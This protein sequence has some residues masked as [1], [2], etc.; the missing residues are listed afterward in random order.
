MVDRK[1]DKPK[2][3]YFAEGMPDLLRYSSLLWRL[4]QAG[5]PQDQYDDFVALKARIGS[6]CPVHGE[7]KD[8]VIAKLGS[9]VAF[10]CPWCSSPQILA[11]WEKE[12]SLS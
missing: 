1:F 3:G 6:L 12:G 8:P 5:C 10:V 11:A 4:K 9:G 2:P 7:L